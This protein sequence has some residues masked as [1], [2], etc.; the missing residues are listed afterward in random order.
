MRNTDR[1]RLDALIFAIEEKAQ[2]AM[3]VTI[4]IKG[5]ILEVKTPYHPDFVQAIKQLPAQD[6]KWSKEWGVWIVDAK[7]ISDVERMLLVHYSMPY[8]VKG[9]RLPHLLGYPVVHIERKTLVLDYLGTPKERNDGSVTAYGMV[10]GEWHLVFPDSVLLKWFNMPESKRETTQALTLYNVLGTKQS[11]TAKELKKH[12]RQVVRQ[13]HPDVCKEENA[14]EMFMKVQR[15]YEV[16]SNP[17]KRKRYNAGLRLA[18]RAKDPFIKA[19]QQLD[20]LIQVFSGTW[21]PPLR[22]GELLV[23]GK[24]V[25]RG[26]EVSKIL[27]WDDIV[28][29]QGQ[30]MV[31]SWVMGQDKPVIEWR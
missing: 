9:N 8:T 14:A 27:K 25:V 1:D 6:R 11:S 17:Q 7:H 28:N 15:A 26:F 24:E 22:C 21:Q 2:K 23:E 12:H 16:L 29:A 4:T 19:V 20:D 13:W 18:S 3:T 30:T 10:N 5:N 31:S